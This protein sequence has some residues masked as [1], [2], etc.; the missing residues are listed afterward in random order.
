[1]KLSDWLTLCLFIVGAATQAGSGAPVKA[2]KKPR[3]L[4]GKKGAAKKK[5]GQGADE[6]REMDIPAAALIGARKGLIYCLVGL[7]SHR[8]YSSKVLRPCLA[9]SPSPHRLCLLRLVHETG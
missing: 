1:M 7:I 3:K 6:G 5:A 4:L 2:V 9:L 8:R